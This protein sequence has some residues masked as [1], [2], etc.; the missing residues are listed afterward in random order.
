MLA[1]V[2]GARRVRLLLSALVLP[3]L[4]GCVSLRQQRLAPGR[5]RS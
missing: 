4:S 2:I 3:G 1:P 5:S